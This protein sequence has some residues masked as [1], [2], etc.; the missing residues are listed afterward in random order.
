MNKNISLYLLIGLTFI[1]CKRTSNGVVVAEVSGSKLYESDLISLFDDNLSF[2]DSAFLRAEF[3]DNWIR[4]QL[5]INESGKILNEEERDFSDELN[6]LK[7]DL[8][9]QST[10]QKMVN[11][12]M[13]TILTDV[14]LK[15]FYE[16]NLDEFELVQN[17][18]KLRFYK[19]SNEIDD[20]Q[21]LWDDFRQNL[22]GIDNTLKSIAEDDGSYF[23]NTRQWLRF[24]EV[25]KEIPITTYNQENFLQNNKF[26]K[27]KDGNYTY[28]IEI[29][30]FLIKSETAPFEIVKEKI[31][32]ILLNQKNIMYREKIESELRENAV[33]QN[34]LIIH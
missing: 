8:L 24:D 19:I 31:K 3:I 11:Q 15:E 6:S 14:E 33:K 32:M 21:Q 9:Y 28:F 5:I 27:V 29:I 34:K 10:L 25:L 1:S 12:R 7:E 23:D 18:V 22:N 20:L 2:E 26:I 17:L 30:D 4:R 16:N 13:D